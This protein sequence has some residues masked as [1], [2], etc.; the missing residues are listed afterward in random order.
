MEIS[1]CFLLC[2]ECAFQHR[3]HLGRKKT[4]LGGK[5]SCTELYL[6]FHPFPPQR[7]HLQEANHK[8][9]LKPL[10]MRPRFETHPKSCPIFQST[11]I[12]G[13]C[14]QWQWDNLFLQ[15]GWAAVQSACN[16]GGEPKKKVCLFYNLVNL[17]AMGGSILLPNWSAYSGTPSQMVAL[18]VLFRFG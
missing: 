10:Q 1:P 2:V 7:P 13:V 15:S 18:K 17:Q 16:W 5:K 4:W 6:P 3:F 11:I 9:T 8:W 14:L 12:A